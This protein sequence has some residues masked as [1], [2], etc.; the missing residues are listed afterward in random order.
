MRHSWRSLGHRL[1]VFAGSFVGLVS[2]FHHVPVLQTVLRGLAAWAL[3]LVIGRL[4]LFALECSLAI[5]RAAS[6]KTKS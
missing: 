2:L 5:E 3:V 4:G 6:D 1:A